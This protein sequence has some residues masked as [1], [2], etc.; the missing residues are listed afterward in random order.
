MVEHMKSASI[1]FEFLDFMTGDTYMS[2]N[3]QN[4]TSKQSNEKSW[5]KYR[6]ENLLRSS[7]GRG[8]LSNNSYIKTSKE[9]VYCNIQ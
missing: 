4:E 2:M 9:K 7:S 8:K 3:A 1:S 5:E 6:N